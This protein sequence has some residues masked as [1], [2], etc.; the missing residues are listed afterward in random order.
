[1]GGGAI[2][3]RES[4]ARPCVARRSSRR[5]W[6]RW[7]PRC[8]SPSGQ[9][10][11][12]HS[13]RAYQ[14]MGGSSVFCVPMGRTDSRMCVLRPCAHDLVPG[15]RGPGATLAAQCRRCGVCVCRRRRLLVAVGDRLPAGLDAP[16]RRPRD[17]LRAGPLSLPS[18]RCWATVRRGRG[19]LAR[20][21]CMRRQPG[22]TTPPKQRTRRRGGAPGAWRRFVRAPQGVLPAAGPSR[23]RCGGDTLCVCVWL[24]AGLA[25][26]SRRPQA[27]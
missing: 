25:R 23:S 27:L 15:P 24:V 10:G 11:G 21:P 6:P 18:M 22:R 26:R 8:W 12:P 9:T 3:R 17:G 7:R 19:P 20:L 1:M 13:Q 2:S 4:R 14:H 5:C 16:T